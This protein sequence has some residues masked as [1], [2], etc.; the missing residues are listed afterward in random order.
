MPTIFTKQKI[1]LSFLFNSLYKL[2]NVKRKFF[3][4]PLFAFILLFTMSI[5]LNCSP[6]QDSRPSEKKVAEKGSLKNSSDSSL[7]NNKELV[8]EKI[9]SHPYLDDLARLIAGRKVLHNQQ[10]FRSLLQDKEYKAYSRRISG[11]WKSFQAKNIVR[12]ENW[13]EKHVPRKVVSDLFYPFGGPDILNALLFFPQVENYYLFGLEPAGKIPDPFDSK[14]KDLISSLKK[15]EV[16][17]RE[18]LSHSF[19]HTKKMKVRLGAR[20][21]F[22]NVFSILLFF[23]SRLEYEIVNF[24]YVYVSKDGKIKEIKNLA[25]KQ[26]S[27]GVEFLIRKPGLA[28]NQGIKKVYFISTNLSDYGLNAHRGISTLF[29]EKTDMATMLKAAS[30][31]M[32]MPSFDDIRSIILSRSRVIFQDPSGIPFLYYKNNPQWEVKLYGRYIRPIPLFRSRC[33][34]DLAQYMKKWSNGRVPFEYGYGSRAFG[35]ALILAERKA[36]LQKPKFDRSS[37]KGENTFCYKNKLV[38]ERK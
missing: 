19:F 1:Y 28:N 21:Q 14:R 34:P 35:T 37:S 11:K 12:I 25:G 18:I 30:Y 16:A 8:S 31:L 20:D 15:F 29:Q 38:H 26:A 10:R 22:N 27:S 33:Q 23:M 17:M 13:S 32:F 7:S 5:S 3:L 2:Y 4:F 9:V 36:P 24:R 6:G